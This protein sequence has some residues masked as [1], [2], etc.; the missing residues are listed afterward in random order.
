M[1]T[2]NSNDTIGNRTRD[3]LTCSAVPQPSA[4]QRTPVNILNM[5][6]S[7]P[8]GIT[9]VQLNSCSV[10]VTAEY[11]F[12]ITIFLQTSRYVPT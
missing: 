11:V 3:L 5:H 2:K 1:S 9:T 7:V 10:V 4:P 12:N 8:G 6:I